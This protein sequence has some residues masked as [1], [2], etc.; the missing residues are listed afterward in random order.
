MS[1]GS[2][3]AIKRVV[4]TGIGVAIVSGLSVAMEV[5]AKKL[6]VLKIADLQLRRP[7]HRVVDQLA[8]SEPEHRR[9]QRHAR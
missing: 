3:E 5:R 4:A 2:T 1:L 7:M 6:A 8:Q 9:V